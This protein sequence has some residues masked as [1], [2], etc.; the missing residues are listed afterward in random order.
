MSATLLALVMDLK[1]FW[2]QEKKNSVSDTDAKKVKV[3]IDGKIK[4]PGGQT[5]KKSTV[6]TLLDLPRE[7]AR[8]KEENRTRLDLAKS[9]I[10]HVPASI[11]ELNQ[12]TELYLYSNRLA[13]LPN[14]VG[15]LVK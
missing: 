3:E 4:R 10:S 11:K 6:T 13:V 14:E 12:L 1:L 8:C 9:N 7:F 5:S 2:L 15:C